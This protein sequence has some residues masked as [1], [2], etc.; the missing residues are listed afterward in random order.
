MRRSWPPRWR[1]IV[2]VADL[3]GD[4]GDLRQSVAELRPKTCD[5]FGVGLVLGQID[6]GHAEAML[7]V[8]RVDAVESQ[9]L[10]AAEDPLFHW[11]T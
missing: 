9:F 2:A 7:G 11:S 3:E 5:G 6:P 10:L 8:P 1:H 4:A